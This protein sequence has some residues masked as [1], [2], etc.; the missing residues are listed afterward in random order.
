MTRNF[1]Q[2]KAWPP[3]APSVQEIE[4]KYQQ[5]TTTP[6]NNTRGLGEQMHNNNKITEMC[7]QRRASPT[8]KY[9]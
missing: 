8:S 1:D 3:N 5:L 2:G 9:Q 7:P 4:G 6:E